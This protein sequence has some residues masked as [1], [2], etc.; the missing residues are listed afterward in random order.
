MDN[1]LNEIYKGYRITVVDPEK[2]RNRVPAI[3][4]DRQMG[5]YGAGIGS[6]VEEAVDAA[7]RKIDGFKPLSSS[8]QF[9][10]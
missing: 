1:W 5:R 6:S 3:I 10:N 9:K 7:K 2:Q 4:T 8:K